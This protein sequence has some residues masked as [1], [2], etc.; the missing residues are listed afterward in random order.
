MSALTRIFHWIV[1]THA[2]VPEQAGIRNNQRERARLLN[3]AATPPLLRRGIRVCVPLFQIPLSSGR[4]GLIVVLFFV[5]PLAA[6]DS[7]VL[8]PADRTAPDPN[9]R[10]RAEIDLDACIDNVQPRSS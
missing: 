8:I 3:G 6:A 5:L 1:P 7:G 2:K 10:S 9:S 4:L